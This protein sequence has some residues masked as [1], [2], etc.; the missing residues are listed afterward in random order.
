[1]SGVVVDL[2]A[3]PGGWDEGLR[4]TGWTGY[5]FGIEMDAAAC[6]TGQAAG[7]QRVRADVATF[8]LGQLVGK[9]EGLIASP[10][11]PSF[12]PAGKQLGKDDM[13]NV[14]RLIADYAAGREPGDYEWA[15]ER[16]PLTAQ[17]MRWA[18]ALR[19]T[20]IALEQVPPV[21]PLWRQIA[22]HLRQLGYS[23]WCGVLSAEEYGVPQ[24]RKRAILMAHLHRNV[25][26]P[27][28]THQGYV[29]GRDAKVAPDLFGEPLP[30]PVSMAEALG[31]VDGIV[32]FPRRAD[33]PSNRVDDDRVIDLGGVGYRAEVACPV[34]D[35]AQV[36]TE[37]ARSWERWTLLPASRTRPTDGT[38][39]RTDGCSRPHCR[40]RSLRHAV[41]RT[42]VPGGARSFEV[43][44]RPAPAPAHTITGQGAAAW[45]IERPATTVVGDARVWPPGHKVNQS[46]RDRH[47]DAD[48]RY[49]D[50]SGTEAVRV[51]VTEAGI[52]QSFPPD[53]PWQGSQTKRYEQVGNAVP[54]LLAR[55]VLGP[56]IDRASERAA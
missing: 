52:L 41:A 20:W 35:P 5:A 33:T 50:R 45:M 21:L 17:P 7:H 43:E 28:P 19:P 9:V 55:A 36:V 8:P 15:D 31:W 12:S 4:M 24:T 49:G 14:V 1:M 27:E 34:S 44:P 32:G 46:D 6:A 2:F 18:V 25:G 48:E 42:D 13:P 54:P 38:L 10:P 40:V 26:R 47:R 11:C 56:L 29:S 16:S 3:G 22:L 39:P 51:S 30:P 53:Y 37:K 23:V